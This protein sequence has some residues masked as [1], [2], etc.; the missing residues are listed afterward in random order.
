LVRGRGRRNFECQEQKDRRTFT[1][2]G[3]FSIGEG[4]DLVE[5]LLVDAKD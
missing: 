1:V 5:L 3:D 4:R 2:T